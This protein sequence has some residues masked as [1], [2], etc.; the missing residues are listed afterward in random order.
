MMTFLRF[1]LV[2]LWVIAMAVLVTIALAWLSYPLAIDYFKISDQ[3]FMSKS[4]ILYNF[5]E[6][7]HYLTY[8]WVSKLA[9][10]SFSS[11][12]AGLAHF[13]DVK[14]L[15]HFTQAVALV[16][17]YPSFRLLRSKQTDLF[18]RSK[19]QGF[20]L[21]AL[22]LPLILALFAICIGFEQFFTLFHQVL[23]P[24]KSNWAFDP[25]TDPVIWLLPEQFFMACFILFFVLYEGSIGL[26]YGLN[27]RHLLK[28]KL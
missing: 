13:K 15:F 23:F 16:L 17:A 8:P 22:A 12:Q 14:G 9:L 27:R 5:K 1:S 19:W 21:L 2:W 11:S 4:S 18:E 28:S 7:M 24:G 10:P 26:L 6:L 25:L 20:Y 3:V